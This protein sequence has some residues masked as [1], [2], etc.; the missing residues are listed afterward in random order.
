MVRLRKPFESQHAKVFEIL[1][2]S[3]RQH[4]YHICSSLFRKLEITLENVSISDIWILRLFA[5]I[6]TA[7]TSIL[8]VLVRMYE[9]RIENVRIATNSNAIS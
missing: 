6:L 9:L 3:A 4:F 7:M 8:Y 5:N 1:L 2:K